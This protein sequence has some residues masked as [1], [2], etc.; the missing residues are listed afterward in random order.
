MLKWRMIVIVLFVLGFALL[1]DG[2]GWLL[3]RSFIPID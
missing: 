1:A 3:G 2:I